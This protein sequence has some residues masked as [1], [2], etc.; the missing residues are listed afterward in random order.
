MERGRTELLRGLAGDQSELHREAGGLVFVVRRMS[1]DYL[2][3][4]LMDDWLSV[5]TLTRASARSKPRC[6]STGGAPGRRG[7]GE[8]GGGGRL[9][10]RGQGGAPAGIAPAGADAAGSG[11]RLSRSQGPGSRFRDGRRPPGQQLRVEQLTA[12]CLRGGRTPC[13]ALPPISSGR[14]RWR[15]GRRDCSAGIRPHRS[16]LRARHSRDPAIRNPGRGSHTRGPS[17]RTRD[18]WSRNRGPSIRSPAPGPRN[19]SRR[20]VGPRPGQRG[21]QAQ[22]RGHH[23]TKHLHVTHSPRRKLGNAWPGPRRF[24]TRRRRRR[25]GILNPAGALTHPSGQAFALRCKRGPY[26]RQIQRRLH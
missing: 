20:S 16:R 25:K 3:P 8:G 24:D 18:L 2:K 14:W 22:A 12:A 11:I 9:R 7:A 4:A 1:L 6:T 23:Y 15:G 17:S 26:F 10:A 5:L 21:H 13:N 19:R